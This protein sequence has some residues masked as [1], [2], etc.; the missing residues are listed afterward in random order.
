M[1]V[2]NVI[3]TGKRIKELMK[4]AGLTYKDLMEVTGLSHMAIYKW[5]YG[6]SMPSID[7]LVIL[8]SVFNATIDE[9]IVVDYR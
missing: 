3:E 4:K 2:V 9:I 8:S 7:N 1:P 5:F 6:Q